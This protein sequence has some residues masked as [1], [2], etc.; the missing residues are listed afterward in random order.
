[1]WGFSVDFSEDNEP[2]DELG[3]KPKPPDAET[4]PTQSEFDD[5]EL[6]GCPREFAECISPTALLEAGPSESL[7]EE[8]GFSLTLDKALVGFADR[9]ALSDPSNLSFNNNPES[10]IKI[11]SVSALE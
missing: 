3:D 4:V 6:S 7:L 11:C 1:M 2:I 5:V 10:S 8:L 9:L